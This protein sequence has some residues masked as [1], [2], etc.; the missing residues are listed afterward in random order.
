[1]SHPLYTI[2]ETFSHRPELRTQW[3]QLS[4]ITYEGS[5]NIP[6][7]CNLLISKNEWLDYLKNYS[8]DHFGIFI[9]DP[10][11]GMTSLSFNY[12]PKN[13]KYT[14]TKYHIK[15]NIMTRTDSKDYTY[16]DIINRYENLWPEIPINFRTSQSK[17]ILDIYS[18]FQILTNRNT[19]VETI[20]DYAKEMVLDQFEETIDYLRGNTLFGLRTF[21]LYLAMNHYLLFGNNRYISNID[22]IND[23]RMEILSW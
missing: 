8:D 12:R 5:A 18:T 1:M 11:N 16:E 21:G 9:L 23:I 10:N 14:V 17:V 13:N 4:R 19:C 22:K 7:S 15:N 6:E 2:S 3:K 20:K